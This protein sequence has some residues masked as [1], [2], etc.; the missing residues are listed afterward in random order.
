[1]LGNRVLLGRDLYPKET[2]AKESGEE[3]QRQRGQR[4]QGG[5]SQRAGYITLMGSHFG[6]GLF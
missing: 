1:M 2:H 3:E 5:I 6:K 4:R